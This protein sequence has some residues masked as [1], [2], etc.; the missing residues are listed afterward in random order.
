MNERFHHVRLFVGRRFGF[1]FIS[2]FIQRS[3]FI[4]ILAM[5][6]VDNVDDE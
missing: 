1:R 6:D 2:N 3:F 5:I 4:Y